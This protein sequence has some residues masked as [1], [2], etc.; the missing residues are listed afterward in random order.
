M[1]HLLLVFLLAVWCFPLLA[2]H[3]ERTLV[4]SFNP[5]GNNHL[6]I[7]L[8]GEL[9]VSP[10][11]ENFVR[12]QFTIQLENGSDAILKGL[13]VAGRYHLAGETGDAFRVHAPGLA[14]T[15][16]QRS[17]PLLEKFSVEVFA[18]SDMRVTQAGAAETGV[19]MV[20]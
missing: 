1:K 5:N 15:L 14:R 3:S 19:G 13:L 2:Q 8:P 10:W 17:H 11:N 6:L 9:S 4:K 12:V 7:D 20:E 18:P 16:P